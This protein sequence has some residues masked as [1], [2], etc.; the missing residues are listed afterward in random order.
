MIA[1]ISL[2]TNDPCL[3]Q[4]LNQLE[5]D[6]SVRLRQH[7]LTSNNHELPIIPHPLFAPSVRFSQLPLDSVPL[8]SPLDRSREREPNPPSGCLSVNDSQAPPAC[9][10]TMGKESVEVCPRSQNLIFGKRL[11][12]PADLPPFRRTV[13]SYLLH[14]VC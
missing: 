7:A 14:D 6:L 9:P 13:L 10:L 2:V 1:I 4:S 12:F 8:H 3:P 5:L 11:I